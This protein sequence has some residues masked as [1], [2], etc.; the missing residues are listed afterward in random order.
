M[1]QLSARIGMAMM[2]LSTAAL[3]GVETVGQKQDA[4]AACSIKGMPGGLVDPGDRTRSVNGPSS[5]NNAFGEVDGKRG[6]SPIASGNSGIIVVD[7][8]PEAGPN[9]RANSALGEVD[10]KP[11]ISVTEDRRALGPNLAADQCVEPDDSGA[12][13]R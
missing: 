9:A 7:G 5:G 4:G 2:V 1:L 3:A 12:G 10:G 11:G 8:V 13:Q 6:I